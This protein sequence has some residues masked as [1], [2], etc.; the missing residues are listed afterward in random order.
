MTKMRFTLL[1]FFLRGFL[2]A[3][4]ILAHLGSGLINYGGDLQKRKYT[5]NQSHGFIQVGMSLQWGSHYIVD[6]SI[7]AGKI[8][9]KD[10][11]N[12]DAEKQE[13]NLS[14]FSNIG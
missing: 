14:F 11:R 6:Y 2:H 1:F 5:F 13:R 12:S 8:S 4:T 7:A 3:Q 9:A 10:S